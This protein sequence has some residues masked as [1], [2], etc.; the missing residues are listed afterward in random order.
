MVAQLEGN[1]KENKEVLDNINV[2]KSFTLNKPKPG[3]KFII[4]F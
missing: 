3:E 2:N 1:I 4:E